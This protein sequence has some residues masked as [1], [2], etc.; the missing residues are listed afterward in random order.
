MLGIVW[1]RA[2]SV[3]D[4]VVWPAVRRG[5][6]VV[7]SGEV[8]GSHARAI[9]KLVGFQCPVLSRRWWVHRGLRQGGQARAARHS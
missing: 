7:A 4:M 8:R 9:G 2:A 5:F 3:Q 1:Q 6:T